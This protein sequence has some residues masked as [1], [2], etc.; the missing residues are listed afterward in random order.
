MNIIYE[1]EIDDRVKS[2]IE[3]VINRYDTS[4]LLYLRFARA[5]DTHGLCRYPKRKLGRKQ[6]DINCWI[7][8]VQD[9]KVQRFITGWKEVPTG[10]T[11]SI[12]VGA[13]QELPKI[14]QTRR[15]NRIYKWKLREVHTET[16]VKKIGSYDI[17]TIE[18]INIEEITLRDRMEMVILLFGHELYHFLRKTK[19]VAGQNTQNQADGF[20]I[21]LVKEWR[22]ICG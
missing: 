21:G 22:T 17:F 14:Y 7:S 20:G 10:Q 11:S 9:L 12:Q 4:K 3:E 8:D 2:Y 6:S 5:K 13:G 1:V 15:F 19:Q 18:P 16:E